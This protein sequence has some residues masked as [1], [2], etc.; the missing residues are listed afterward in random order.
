MGLGVGGHTAALDGADA[1]ALRRT[2]VEALAPAFGAKRVSEELVDVH[3]KAWI[4]DDLTY[5]PGGDQREFGHPH[6]REPHGAIHFA[7]TES[8]D[9]Y[10]HVEGALKAAERAAAEVTAALGL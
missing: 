9:E 4:A 3:A 6:L 1:P 2:V 8:E 10:G 5:N 7:G